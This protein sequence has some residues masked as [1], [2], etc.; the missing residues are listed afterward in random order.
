MELEATGTPANDPFFGRAQKLLATNQREEQ[1]KIELVIP[2]YNDPGASTAV[3]SANYHRTHFGDA[4]GLR[5]AAGDVA[6]SACIAF[7]MERIALAL[8]RSHGFDPAAWPSSVRA[9]MGS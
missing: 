5:T 9:S 1:L 4:F 8:I 3:V 7:G 2:L 6:H